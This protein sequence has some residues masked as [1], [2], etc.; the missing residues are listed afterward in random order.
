LIPTAPDDRH[1]AAVLYHLREVKSDDGP[2]VSQHGA[3]SLRP[4]FDTR[5]LSGR[6]AQDEV[7]S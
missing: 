3:R 2:S 6:A 4:S 7:R 5:G 1:G